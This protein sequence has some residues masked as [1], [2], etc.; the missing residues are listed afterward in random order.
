MTRVLGWTY[1]CRQPP[2]GLGV[3]LMPRGD[4]VE[5]QGLGPTI[6]GRDWLSDVQA[7]FRGFEAFL[8]NRPG[9][10]PPSLDQVRDRLAALRGLGQ[11]RL[12]MALPPA[13]EV[14]C[15]QTGRAYLRGLRDRRADE[16]AWR[17]T[18]MEFLECVAG[19]VPGRAQKMSSHATGVSLDLLVPLARERGLAQHVSRAIAEDPRGRTAPGQVVASGLWAPVAFAWA[20][21]DGDV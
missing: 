18:A 2:A 20:D 1:P 6:T 11:L 7:C 9:P 21:G 17:E 3:R 10:E 4:L 15:A 12:R 16:R 19:R 14:R 13:R 8:P 5:V